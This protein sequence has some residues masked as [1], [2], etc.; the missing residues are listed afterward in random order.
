MAH[1][2]LFSRASSD[3][4]EAIRLDKTALSKASLL[5]FLFFLVILYLPLRG[6]GA[7]AAGVGD[8]QFGDLLQPVHQNDIF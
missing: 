7:V 5:S 8:L 1:S 3:M 4:M 2:A 6:H